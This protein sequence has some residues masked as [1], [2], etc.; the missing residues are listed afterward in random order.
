MARLEAANRSRDGVSGTDAA[1]DLRVFRHSV[2]D[3]GQTSDETQVVGVDQV[4]SHRWHDYGQSAQS[5]PGYD[6]SK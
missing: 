6:L 4:C 5:S 2:D 3:A 1:P